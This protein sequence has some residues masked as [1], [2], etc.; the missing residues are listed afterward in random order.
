[1]DSRLLELLDK[2]IEENRILKGE[3][4]KKLINRDL[5]KE[6]LSYFNDNYDKSISIFLICFSK[7]L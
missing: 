5:Y 2:Y 3:Y 4:Q 7:R 6:L 1:M